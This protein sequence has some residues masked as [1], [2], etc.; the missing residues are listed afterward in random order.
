LPTLT[1]NFVAP[2]AVNAPPDA[3]AAPAGAAAPGKTAA[4][5]PPKKK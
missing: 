2:V 3:G 5:P 4:T 1:V